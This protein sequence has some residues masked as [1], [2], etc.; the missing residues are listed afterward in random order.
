MISVMDGQDAKNKCGIH[1]FAATPADCGG[2]AVSPTEVMPALT[3]ALSPRRGR[4]IVCLT[5]WQRFQ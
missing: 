2:A 1:Q 4:I 3:P 5:G